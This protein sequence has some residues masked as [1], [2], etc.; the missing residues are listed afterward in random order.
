MKKTVLIVEDSPTMRNMIKVTLAGDGFDCSTAQDGEKALKSARETPYTLI[1]TDI[2][3]PNMDG[4]EMIRN[5]RGGTANKDTPILVVTTESGEAIKAEAKTAGANGWIV[6]PF[7][8]EVLSRAA[9]K[10]A[11]TDQAGAA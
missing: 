5:I 4:I 6:K 10:L 3:M 7:K 2:N 9:S 1:V 11:G 8:P